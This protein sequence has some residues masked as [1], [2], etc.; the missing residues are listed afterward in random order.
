[1][2][3][4]PTARE[5]IPLAAQKFTSLVHE[6]PEERWPTQTPCTEWSVRDLVNH[7]VAEHLWAPHV[8]AGETIEQVG[9]RYDGDVVGEDPVGAWDSAVAGSLAAFADSEE[10]QPVHLS[11]GTV[12]VSEYA[13]QMLSDLTV[14]AWDLARGAGLDERLEEATVA[15]TLAYTEDHIDVFAGSS[16]FAEPVEIDSDDPQDRLLA[17][18][19]RDPR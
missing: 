6:V 14:H 8:L 4:Q 5:L 16:L 2:S 17:L 11:F 9:D 3:Q 7:L 1:M 10:D 18:L 19:G 12:P 13:S 15:A